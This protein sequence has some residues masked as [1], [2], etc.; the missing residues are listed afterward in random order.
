MFGS[1]AAQQVQGHSRCKDTRM[2]LCI[3]IAVIQL[4]LFD[5]HA[6]ELPAVLRMF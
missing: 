4:L 6:W 2:L 5:C 1:A 3:G